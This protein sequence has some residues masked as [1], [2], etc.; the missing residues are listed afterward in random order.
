MPRGSNPNGSAKK[1]T[2]YQ[3]KMRVRAG[4]LGGMVG[5]Q[6]GFAGG[7]LAG[8][9]APKFPTAAA[10]WN[11]KHNLGDLGWEASGQ[12]LGHA[13]PLRKGVGVKN[14]SAKK[15]MGRSG[16]ASGLAGAGVG[17]VVGGGSAYRAMA[18]QQ[19]KPRRRSGGRRQRRDRHGKFA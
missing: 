14:T 19:A 8:Q 2:R 10:K 13:V 5:A 3:R 18:R 1:P 9:R 17:A 16:L 6:A 7:V 12:R 4:I 11:V 15:L